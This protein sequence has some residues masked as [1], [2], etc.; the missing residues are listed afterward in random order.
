[1]GLRGKEDGSLAPDGSVVLAGTA[2]DGP[3]LFGGGTTVG[4][5]AIAVARL[6]AAC[7]PA[8]DKPPSLK[9]HCSAG[10]RRMLGTALDTPAGSGVRRVLLGI[11]RIAGA[12]CQ[13]WNGQKLVPLPCAQAATR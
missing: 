12:R 2:I 6:E 5:S 3:I 13:A 10:C 1:M 4:H 7:P 11:E 8:D 9:I